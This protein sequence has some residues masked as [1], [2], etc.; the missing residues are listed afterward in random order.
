MIC[1]TTL[2][3]S[4]ECRVNISNKL[5]LAREKRTSFKLWSVGDSRKIHEQDIFQIFIELYLKFNRKYLI[6]FSH[7][8]LNLPTFNTARFHEWANEKKYLYQWLLKWRKFCR[9]CEN[10]QN[11]RFAILFDT[12]TYT[13]CINRTWNLNERGWQNKPSWTTRALL[14]NFHKVA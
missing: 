13:R 3:V 12:N 9:W 14:S 4:C 6:K 2:A 11:R 10:F 8:R 1:H 5:T 7:S